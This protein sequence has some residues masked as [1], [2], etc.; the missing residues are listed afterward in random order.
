MIHTRTN[1]SFYYKA[2]DID[3]ADDNEKMFTQLK[4]YTYP[5]PIL[6]I[7]EYSFTLKTYIN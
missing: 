6:S 1:R 2:M 7:N 3:H 4:I 5:I